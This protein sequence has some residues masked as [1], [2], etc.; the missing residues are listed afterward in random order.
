MIMEGINRYNDKAISRAQ[1]IQTISIL[2]ED[3]SVDNGTLTPT[4]KL[5]RK[6]VLKKHATLIESMYIEPK[7]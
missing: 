1:R 7:L 6:E 5:K 4:L 2:L 3:F